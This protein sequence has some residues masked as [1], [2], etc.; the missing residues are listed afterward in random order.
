MRYNRYRYNPEDEEELDEEAL[1][2]EELD[3]D[4]EDAYPSY[5]EPNEEWL[6]EHGYKDYPDDLPIPRRRIRGP[7]TPEGATRYLDADYPLPG[8]FPEAAG[9]AMGAP[10]WVEYLEEREVY[11][12]A[13]LE[14]VLLKV[15]ER[16]V[17]RLA[18]SD[19][20]DINAARA[21]LEFDRLA[22]FNPLFTFQHAVLNLH[23]FS[24]VL[25]F[26][27]NGIPHALHWHNLYG[28]AIDNEYISEDREEAQD[29]FYLFELVASS[30]GD[31]NSYY[32]VVKILKSLAVSPG[33]FW[34]R[35][36]PPLDKRDFGIIGI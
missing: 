15:R 10:A 5:P 1:D 32:P 20:S 19:Y 16:L 13:L 17:Q 4:D 7:H 21:I 18:D 14:P 31:E 26:E 29:D 2:E 34:S 12:G 35:I 8:S 27:V 33:R 36:S 28:Y 22:G 30:L 3:D 6:A 23:K 9:R 24:E 11:P 25:I